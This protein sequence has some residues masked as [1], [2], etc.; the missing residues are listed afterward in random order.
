MRRGICSRCNSLIELDEKESNFECPNCHERIFTDSAIKNYYRAV[1]TY[2][3]KAEIAL[4]GSTDYPLAFKNYSLL[5]ELVEKDLGVLFNMAIA[6]LYCSNLHEIHLKEATDLIL[7]GSDKVEIGQ[8]NVKN[9]S[10]A[11]IRVRKDA[12]KLVD[13]FKLVANESNYALNLYHQ[14]FLQTDCGN[15]S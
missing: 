13:A 7:K 5:H 15:V 2:D 6:K 9:L 10:D 1:R 11:L 14:A 12:K 3:K 4:L 8:D